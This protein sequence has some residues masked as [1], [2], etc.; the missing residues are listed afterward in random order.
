MHI[1]HLVNSLS[2]GGAEQTIYNLVN[3]D[4]ETNYTVCALEGKDDLAPKIRDAGAEVYLAKEQFRFDPRALKRLHRELKQRQIDVLH[5]HLAYAQIV[6]RLVAPRTGIKS[7]VSTQHSLQQLSHPVMRSLEQFTKARDDTSVAV[8]EGVRASFSDLGRNRTWET[9]Y[10]GID[11]TTFNHQV[12]THSKSTVSDSGPIFLNVGRCVPPKAQSIL[13]KAMDDVVMELPEAKL[14]IAGDG[15]LFKK[16]QEEILDRG[17]ERNIELVGHASPI[18]PYYA[19]ADV[20]V[21]PSRIEG[22]PISILEA[23]AAEL[24]VIASDIPGVSEVVVEGKTGHL[25]SPNNPTELATVMIST[26]KGNHS[27]LGQAG[28]NRV[29]KQFNTEQMLA[30]YLKLYKSL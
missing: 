17:L 24:P 9:I 6:G 14:I 18:E 29:K 8:S 16:L 12:I 19:K 11:V 25:V 30:S 2:V 3:A 21:L 28:F 7:I 1:C 10:N 22:L 23:M 5:T 4:D 27:E 15:P 13:I 20:F 26:V